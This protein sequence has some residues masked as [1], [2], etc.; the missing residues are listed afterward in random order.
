MNDPASL[1]PTDT[2][3][4]DS[5][6]RAVGK[7]F[8]GMSITPQLVVGFTDAGCT[9]TWGQSPMAPGCSA[10]RCHPGTSAHDSMETT[11]KSS[12]VSSCQR[13][14]GSMSPKISSADNQHELVAERSPRPSRKSFHEWL[15][16]QWR[17]WESNPRPPACKAS[18]LA[19]LHLALEKTIDERR[20][21][22][23]L[24]VFQRN[25]VRVTF[26]F[27]SYS[28]T[29]TSVRS[30]TC[31]RSATRHDSPAHKTLTSPTFHIEGR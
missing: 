23:D 1:S 14:F 19:E 18:A 22:W 26:I 10:R 16:I 28:A 7:P 13:T 20:A 25:G 9:A 4:W 21:V 15:T 24:I 8:P 17:R 27:G 6:Q 31:A 12:K 5:I 11:N 3:L 29:S 2:P 30:A